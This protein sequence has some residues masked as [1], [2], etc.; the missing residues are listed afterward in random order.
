MSI[1]QSCGVSGFVSYLRYFRN[2]LAMRSSVGLP[3]CASVST[4]H[5]RQPSEAQW[6]GNFCPIHQTSHLWSQFRS[7][8]LAL[9]LKTDGVPR[10]K[11]FGRAHVSFAS[12]PESSVLTSSNVQAGVGLQVMILWR[13]ACGKECSVEM[14]S[15]APSQIDLTVLAV[16]SDQS[17]WLHAY[18]LCAEWR[19]QIHPS[20]L[21]RT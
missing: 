8:L 9:G 5:Q 7:I 1:A 15:N 19:Q 12:G 18:I 4:S 14:N 10:R 21:L 2:W 17:T 3:P 20:C 13:R 6:P 11:T 16:L